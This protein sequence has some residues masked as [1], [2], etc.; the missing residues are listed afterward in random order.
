MGD[1]SE[2]ERLAGTAV[3]AVVV[4]IAGLWA[5]STAHG[6]YAQGTVEEKE[7]V[8]AEVL[9]ADVEYNEYDLDDETALEYVPRVEYTY[10]Y[11]GT[12]YTSDTLYRGPE[13]VFDTWEEAAAAIDEYEAGTET[14]AYIDATEPDDAYLIDDRSLA[15]PAL[16]GGGG[17]VAVGLVSIGQTIYVRRLA[18]G[19]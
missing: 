18:G 16:L 15:L 4:L 17:L 12:T 8:E 10:T 19:G 6:L 2:T 7:L 11:D 14:T 1:R 13:H 5:I 3:F 9:T